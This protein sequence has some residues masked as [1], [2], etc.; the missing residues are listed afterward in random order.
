[1]IQGDRMY[2]S[3]YEGGLRVID[4]EN[5]RKLKARGYFDTYPEGENAT[6]NGAWGVY[7]GFPSGNLIV[8]DV[9]RGLFVIR[10]N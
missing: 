3:A 9:Q 7:A 1:M 6:F 5:P 4:V 2:V 10:A 8:S